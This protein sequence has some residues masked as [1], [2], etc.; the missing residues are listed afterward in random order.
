MKLQ[1]RAAFISLDKHME[2]PENNLPDK[3]LNISK[4]GR[5]AK[6]DTMLKAFLAY[7]YFVGYSERLHSLAARVGTTPVLMFQT[8]RRHKWSQHL[9][10]VVAFQK[11]QEDIARVLDSAAPLQHE[12]PL[13]RLARGV[14]NLS[15]VLINASQKY[16]QTASLMIDYYS[17]RIAN[18]IAEAGGLD[19]LDSAAATVVQGYQAQLTY[20]AKAIE[21]F[22][23]PGAIAAL[24]SQ[25]NF[26]EQ[27][28]NEQQES[29]DYAAFTM[30]ELIASARKYGGLPTAFDNP[31]AAI[32]PYVGPEGLPDISGLSNA[33]PGEVGWGLSA[34]DV[35]NS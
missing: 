19:H 7:P 29:I 26:K 25:V 1:R 4:L 14:K 6:L 5:K 20:Y 2:K 27:I 8:A 10:R 31:D 23:K 35:P 21:G 13:S 28:P 17:N 22:L 9:E 12:V 30:S 32:D 11:E 15:F 16:V 33:R 24:L 3:K 18:T 34:P